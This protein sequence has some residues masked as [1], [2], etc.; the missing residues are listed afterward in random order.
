MPH[1]TKAVLVWAAFAHAIASSVVLLV[2]AFAL[3]HSDFHR[4]P[5]LFI[6]PSEPLSTGMTLPLQTD[7]AHFLLRV[8][9]CRHGDS[10]RVF[11]GCSGEFRASIRAQGTGSRVDIRD[12]SIDICEK[13]R[14]MDTQKSPAAPWLLFAPIKK[15][16]IKVLVEKAT[17]LGVAR[18][19]PVITDRTQEV[20]DDQAMMKFGSTIIEA[21][22]LIPGL[23]GW[24]GTH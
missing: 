3:V 21:R 5:R 16:R 7:Q 11:D 19:I 13:L 18:L 12:A 20:P 17:E 9:R 1:A 22:H 23:F 8:M 4:L 24:Q 10:L 15:Q 2:P 6:A 14:S